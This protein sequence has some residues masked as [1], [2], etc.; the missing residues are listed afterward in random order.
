M[1]DVEATSPAPSVR[2]RRL[3]NAAA[4][5]A[6]TYSARV[7]VASNV[8]ERV[9]KP[10]T[11]RISAN[12]D[13]SPSQVYLTVIALSFVVILIAS[14]LSVRVVCPA[15]SVD[16][17]ISASV[18][19]AVRR[20]TGY[21]KAADDAVT[22]RSARAALRLVL[23]DPQFAGVFSSTV[24]SVLVDSPAQ[25]ENVAAVAAVLSEALATAAGTASRLNV[26]IEQA[27]A[28]RLHQARLSQTASRPSST[29][30]PATD[31]TVTESSLEADPRRT[32]LQ[33]GRTIDTRYTHQTCYV[34]GDE[35][36]M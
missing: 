31:T 2:L 29:F 24:A 18:P 16:N 8:S 6:S 7:V 35:S 27:T 14:T 3:S 33:D 34:A 23:L 10:A 12:R 19:S 13:R 20:R 26:S 22:L 30:S 4:T 17:D 11:S 32:L 28:L 15:H 1:S 9:H 36:E 5:Q 21:A 25:F